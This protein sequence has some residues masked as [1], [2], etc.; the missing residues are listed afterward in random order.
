MLS[1]YPSVF[2]PRAKLS[3][4][5]KRAGWQGFNYD[6]RELPPIATQQVYPLSA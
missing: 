6:L 4:K 3:E 5:A 2:K 1:A